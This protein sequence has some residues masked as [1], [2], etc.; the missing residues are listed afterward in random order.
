MK[1]NGGF[2]YPVENIRAMNGDRGM[3]MRDYFAGQAM[4]M[5]E[6]TTFSQCAE[7]SYKYADAM[8]EESRK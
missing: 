4:R 6:Y 8:I 5:M 2:V 1:D 3:S 7:A